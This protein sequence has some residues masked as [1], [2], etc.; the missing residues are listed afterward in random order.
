MIRSVPNKTV[1]K[2]EKKSVKLEFPY[3][4]READSSATGIYNCPI[5]NKSFCVVYGAWAYR[6]F[7]RGNHYTFC[8]WGCARQADKIYEEF[9]E[10]KKKRKAM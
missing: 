6:R 7:W 10:S 1:S 2:P 5:C 3:K 9:L 8:S 4:N